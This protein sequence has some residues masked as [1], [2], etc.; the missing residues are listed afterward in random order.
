MKQAIIGYSLYTLVTE[1]RNT[2]HFKMFDLCL[3]LVE[4][5]YALTQCFRIL[6]EVNTLIKTK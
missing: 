1:P 2:L 4:T 5:H 3:S 6:K